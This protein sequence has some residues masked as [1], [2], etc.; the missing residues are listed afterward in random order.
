MDFVLHVMLDIKSVQEEHAF[1]LKHLKVI[2]TAKHSKITFVVNVLKEPY[3]I[4]K[5]YV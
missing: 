1:K 5:E 2:L 3:L 4:A